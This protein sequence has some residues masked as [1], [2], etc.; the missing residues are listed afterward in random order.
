[1]IVNGF[2]ISHSAPVPPILYGTAWKKE[3]TTELVI[4]ALQVGYRGIDVACQPKHYNEPGVGEA[5]AK[6]Y[7]NGL[8]RREDV[9][10]QTKY[11]PIRGQ[12]PANV[13]YDKDA[14]LED[15]VYQSYQASLRNLKT[16]YLDR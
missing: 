11:T 8:L 3:R 12:D 2:D 9:F 10:L 7:E 1:M 16:T 14:S 4:E 13:P 5:L 15:S 6:C